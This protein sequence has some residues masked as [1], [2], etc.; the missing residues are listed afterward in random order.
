MANVLS[1]ALK[2]NADASGLRL[3]PVERALQRLGA[4]TDKVTGVFDK[5]AGTSEAASR[6]QAAT[7]KSLEDL[8]KARRAGTISAQQFAEEFERVRDAALQEAAALQRAAQI[9]EANLTPLQRYDRSLAEL[10]EQLRAGRISQETYGRA[11]ENASRGLTDA[12]RA[13]RGLAVQQKEIDTA[14]T[15]TTLKFNELSGVF[16]VLPGPLGNIAGRIS[17]IASASEGLSRIFAGGLRSGLSNLVASVTSLINPLTVAV[18]GIGAFAVA[19]ASF[20]RALIALEDRVERLGNQAAQL[21]VSFQFI[22]VIE[23]TA[24]RS[25]VSIG[26]LEGAFTRLQRTIIEA[27]DGT[28][29]AVD[30][31]NRL[32]LVASELSLLE[33]Q[34]QFLLIGERIAGI[35]DP[36]LRTAAAVEIFGRSGAQLL[37]FFNNLEGAAEDIE[38]VGNVLSDAQ[39]RDIDAF[40]RSMD[41]LAV[42]TQGASQQLT[43]ELA[44]GATQTANAVSAAAGVIARNAGTIVDSLGATFNLVLPGTVSLLNQLGESVEQAEQGTA[45]ANAAADATA[46]AFSRSAEEVNALA[47]AFENSQKG[48]DAAIAKAGEF[49]QAGFDAAFEFQQALAD[50]E[51]QA[52]E[53]ELNAEQYARGV[54]NATAEL[55]R[56]LD[57][58]SRV[59]EENRR[60]ADEAQKQADAITNRV[61]GLLAKAS[62]V[63]RIEQDLSAVESEI[64]RVEA[65]QLAARESGATA[66]AEALASRLAQLDQLQ[67]GL[68]EQQDEAAQG[69][70]QGFDSAFA[71]VDRGINSLIDK[72]AEFGN[73]GAIAAQQLT[74]GIAQ[75][76]EQARDGILNR[77][78]FDAQVAQQRELFNERLRQLEQ[79]QEQRLQAERTIADE[80][81]RVNKLVDDQLALAAFDGNSARLAA[82]RNV[83]AIE[84]EIARVQAEVAAA[85][86]ANDGE[87]ARLGNARIAQL[88]E[89]AAKERDIANGRAAREAEIARRREQAAARERQLI[90][91]ATRQREE[92]AR[93]QQAAVQQQQEAQRKAFEEQARA[94]AAEAERQ[95]RRIRALR[96]IGQQSIGGTDI[97]STEGASQFIQAA[98]GAFDPNL[99]ELRAQSKLLRQIVVNSG[100]LRFL[101]QGIGSTFAFLGG[102]A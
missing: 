89:I 84:Q 49:G 101:E 48:L 20:T 13:A 5:F 53:G 8:T 42:A 96:S 55:E 22:Q 43:A 12:E 38:R 102:G 17:G 29:T 34:E 57:V 25:G 98:A 68:L 45:D 46:E 61:D 63:S 67:A 15:S 10:D 24:R 64:A 39:R 59:A 94:A 81:R 77:E 51:E 54:A 47:S 69:F 85:R 72:A 62:E 82:S 73:E 79:E 2:I 91:Q 97:R 7:A 4:E 70:A 93:Q 40:G 28:K 95:D 86:L 78:A 6:A 56:Q 21:G 50:L 32:G 58:A 92:A 36:A 52:L 35:E 75:A 26:S 11:V 90:E 76:Q 3:T 14:A 88:N 74:Q 80:R 1:L 27:S 71:S 87:A 31:L 23:E 37:P 9:T 19:S 65:A 99:A 100:A 18:G 44:P 16:S 33:E 41:R 60:I 30:A 66:Q 83:Q